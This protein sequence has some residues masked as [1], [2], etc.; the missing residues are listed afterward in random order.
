MGYM[1][2]IQIQLM[3]GDFAT[4]RSLA[5][6]AGVLLIQTSK[7]LYSTCRIYNLIT[8]TRERKRLRTIINKCVRTIMEEN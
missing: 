8:R 3:N 6:D 7:D 2:D 5:L 1:K 4:P